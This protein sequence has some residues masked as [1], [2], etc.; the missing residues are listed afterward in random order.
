M[1][2]GHMFPYYLRHRRGLYR[3]CQKL[4]GLELLAH[5]TDVASNVKE[6]RGRTTEGFIWRVQQLVSQSG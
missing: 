2:A 4:A 5:P 1:T 3:W 6:K